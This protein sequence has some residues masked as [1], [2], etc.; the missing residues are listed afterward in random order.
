MMM[1]RRR[2]KDVKWFN[3]VFIYEMKR[4]DDLETKVEKEQR[5]TMMSSININ[6]S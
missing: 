1:M 4:E 5:V 3:F 2:R 6:N